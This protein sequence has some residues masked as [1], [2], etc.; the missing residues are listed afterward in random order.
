MFTGIHTRLILSVVFK[1]TLKQFE[2]NP[3]IERHRFVKKHQDNTGP[4]CGT[5]FKVADEQILELMK[6][7]RVGKTCFSNKTRN[8]ILSRSKS[9][10]PILVLI[11][12]A[13]SLHF[14]TRKKIELEVITVD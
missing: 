3:L 6:G 2:Y 8:W 9:S 12:V 4:N 10:V 11:Y 5:V 1:F 14:V 13:K 7:A